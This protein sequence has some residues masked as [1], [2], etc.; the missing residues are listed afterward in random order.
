MKPDPGRFTVVKRGLTPF[1]L[2]VLL[3][4]AGWAAAIL[5]TRRLELLGLSD[6]GTR[7]LDSYAVLAALDAARAGLDPHAA[8]TF[9]PLLR[10]HVYS[11]WWLA[12]KWTGLGRAQNLFVGLAWVGAFGVTVWASLRPKTWREALWLALLLVS[13]PVLLALIRANNDLVIF[14]LL[15]ACGVALAGEGKHRWLY[16][17]LGIGLATGL[18]YYPAVAILML[19]WIRPVR[20]MPLVFGTGLLLAGLALV[21]VL[22]ALKRAPLNVPPGLYT[23]GAPIWWRDLGWTDAQA[24]L[25]AVLLFLGAGAVLAFSKTTTGLA[26]RGEPRE[27][28]LAALSVSLLLVCFISGI[29]FA[30]RWI[31]AIWVA[32]WLWRRSREALPVREHV[33]AVSGTLLVFI[34]L[35]SDGILCLIVNQLPPKSPAWIEHLLLVY[36]AWTQ[37]LHWVLMALLA[38]WLLEAVLA[39]GREW[40]QQRTAA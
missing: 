5:W 16:A 3:T 33:A 11:D 31:F 20:Q 37:P 35:W 36:R 9:D 40:R 4:T 21:S 39:T 30:Y 10:Y 18:K 24:L 2:L 28:V 7:F 12:L 13:P 17:I 29:N 32:L 1:S 19:L 22:P 23:M 14:A 27:R 26:S 8:N 34:C 15:G 38:G 6:F 25:P